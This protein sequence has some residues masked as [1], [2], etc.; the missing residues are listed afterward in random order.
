MAASRDVVASREA[1][2]GK[3]GHMKLWQASSLA[4]AGILALSLGSRDARAEQPRMKAS[5]QRLEDAKTQLQ[6]ATHD[7]AGHR[8]KALSYINAAI[9]EV[10]AGIAADARTPAKTTAPTAAK[11]ATTTTP[12]PATT[13]PAPKPAAPASPAAPHTEPVKNPK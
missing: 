3:G 13:N 12:K 9:A 4:V 6:F 11:P 7:K 2:V 8:A 10:K 1:R 5:L